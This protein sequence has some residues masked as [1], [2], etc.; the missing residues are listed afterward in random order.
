MTTFGVGG[1]AEY[2]VRPRSDQEL[3]DVLDRAA[4][5]GIEVRVLGTAG[6]PRFDV[7]AFLVLR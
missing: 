4:K 1:P 6:H 2:F 3:R 7:D 5:A